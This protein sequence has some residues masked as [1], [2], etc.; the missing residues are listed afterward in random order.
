VLTG[1]AKFVYRCSYYLVKGLC[2][3]FFRLR[4]EGLSNI[5]RT[6]AALI[7]SNHVSHLDPPII[8]VA[9]RRVVFHMAKRELLTVAPLRW[10]MTT[11]RS[12]IVDRGRG[13]QALLEAGSYLQRGE[14]V[15]IFPEGTRSRNG[16]LAKGHSGAVV[17]AIRSGCPV[18]P[19]AIIGSERAMTKGSKLIRPVP[20]TVRFGKPFQ[21]A[22]DGDREN[23][24]RET[25]ERERY[26]LM[27]KIEELLPDHMR[28][29]L[30]EKRKWYGELSA[31]SS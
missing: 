9:A 3:L 28:P 24:P 18:V 26:L 21:V 12:I 16:Q 1:W 4:V 29:P 27:E 6:G 30:E 31:G 5:P 17:L 25:I 20:V 19:A 15:V 8:G 7:A 10:Y 22:Y 14:A 2:K 11:I 23:I 13:T